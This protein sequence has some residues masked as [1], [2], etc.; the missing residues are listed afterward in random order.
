MRKLFQKRNGYDPDK[1][2]T[3]VSSILNDR[4]NAIKVEQENCIEQIEMALNGA[5]IYS[6]CSKK[7]KT[8]A[9]KKV[10]V[11]SPKSGRK[12]TDDDKYKA[13][14]Y[15][16]RN[17]VGLEEIEKV[18]FG[19]ENSGTTAKVCLNKLGIDTSRKTVHK[20]LLCAI[21]ANIDDEIAK[22]SDPTFKATLE[23][24]KKRG[25]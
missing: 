15:Y 14:A 3:I 13:A 24:I 12:Y 22:A 1:I 25:L 19:C 4:Y 6:T 8:T 9:T 21:G 20:G 10:S 17:N 18:C 11:K 7:A 23:E 5:G 2:R 16:L